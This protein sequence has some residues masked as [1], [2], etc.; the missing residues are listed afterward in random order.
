MEQ[1]IK[2]RGPGSAY[3]QTPLRWLA[4]WLVYFAAQRECTDHPQRS[5]RQIHW[6]AELA[7]DRRRDAWNDRSTRE[8]L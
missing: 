2:A 4:E 7:L 1:Y 6:E 8:A 3:E 5:L